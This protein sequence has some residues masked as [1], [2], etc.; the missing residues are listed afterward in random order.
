MIKVRWHHA[1]GGFDLVR[2]E[3]MAEG[4]QSLGQFDVETRNGTEAREKV[5][6]EY[7]AYTDTELPDDWEPTPAALM[8]L[9]ASIEE[10]HSSQD[11]ITH[12]SGTDARIVARLAAMVDAEVAPY[13]VEEVT[14]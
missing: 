3:D 11:R 4:E 2:A 8:H 12:V 14:A 6:R 13:E 7:I 1:A 9:V 5:D 10:R